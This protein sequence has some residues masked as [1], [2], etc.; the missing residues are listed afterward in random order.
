[1]EPVEKKPQKSSAHQNSPNISGYTSLHGIHFE[2]CG[3]TAS[4]TEVW[5]ALLEEKRRI[6]DKGVH[7]VYYTKMIQKW[8]L[9]PPSPH[10]LSCLGPKRASQAPPRTAPPPR[11]DMHA[12]CPVRRPCGQSQS[13]LGIKVARD[14]QVKTRWQIWPVQLCHKLPPS[15]YQ[16]TLH[17]PHPP[18]IPAPT[19]PLRY[20]PAA[21]QCGCVQRLSLRHSS[22]ASRGPRAAF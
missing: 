7:L 12:A 15:L 6:L 18:Q 16:K 9:M 20:H 10:C 13:S 4:P 8:E 5:E 11:P 3:G 21:R 14:S 19:A 1:M 17:F 22:S 2:T